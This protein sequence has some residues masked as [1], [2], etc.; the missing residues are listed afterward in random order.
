[1]RQAASTSSA[2]RALNAVL[3]AHAA[4][5]WIKQPDGRTLLPPKDA[6]SCAPYVPPQPKDAER[7]WTGFILG[8]RALF[9]ALKTDHRLVVL[10]H[11]E[12]AAFDQKPSHFDPFDLELFVFDRAGRRGFVIWSNGDLEGGTLRLDEKQGAWTIE[13]GSYWIS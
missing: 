2:A 7:E 6:E 5:C 12:A 3:R 1:V 9:T 8:D 4:V 13:E 10:T 11:E